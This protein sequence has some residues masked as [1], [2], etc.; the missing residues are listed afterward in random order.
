MIKKFAK[1]NDII[2]KYEKLK[3][4]I[5]E[6]QEMTA[7]QYSFM[8]P[9]KQVKGISNYLESYKEKIKKK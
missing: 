8:F 5:K 7:N 6:M 3:L 4:Y 9:F 2:V 1:D